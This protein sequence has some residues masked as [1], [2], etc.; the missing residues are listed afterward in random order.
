MG[1]CI[2]CSRET[3]GNNKICS[4]CS[5]FGEIILSSPSRA[6]KEKALLKLVKHIRGGLCEE[7]RDS[8]VSVGIDSNSS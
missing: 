8:A 1:K 3:K 2:W 5:W 7:N 6:T 4:E